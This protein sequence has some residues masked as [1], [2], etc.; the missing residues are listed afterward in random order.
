MFNIEKARANGF[1]E[2]SIKIMQHINENNVK[3]EECKGH[4]FSVPPDHKNPMVWVCTKCGYEADVS[5]VKG[6]HDA[7]K[8]NGIAKEGIS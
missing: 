8:K 5:Y 3:C 2:S 4:D 7:E 1:P 6:Y